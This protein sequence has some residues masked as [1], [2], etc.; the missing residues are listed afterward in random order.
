[1]RKES[2]LGMIVILTLI[3]AASALSLGY[4]Y[5]VTS[6]KIKGEEKKVVEE[7]L[8]KVLPDA[9]PEG[10]KKIEKKTENGSF[11]YYEA[12]DKPL[13]SED[14][15]LIGYATTGKAKG[16]SSEIKVMV[17]IGADKKK[18]LGVKVLVQQETPGLG[19]Q[20][21]EE[22]VDKKLWAPMEDTGKPTCWTDQFAGKDIEGLTV[23]KGKTKEDTTGK[24]V[25]AITGAT[26]TSKAVVR[27][28]CDDAAK[29]LLKALEEE[30]K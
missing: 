28:A 19:T 2:P 21:Q 24:E 4:L 22:K 18:F 9:N 14:K 26:I 7:S 27:A 6:D 1:M 12:Y 20:C 23:V 25:A 15:K 30:P 3:C 13:T 10:F 16:Y 11:V 8:I 29:N 17:G 5:M